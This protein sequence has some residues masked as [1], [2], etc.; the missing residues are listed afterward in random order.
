MLT[1]KAIRM[2]ARMHTFFGP[3]GPLAASLPCFEP[4]SEQADL[5]EAVADALVAD[6]HLVAEAGTGT[7]K[8]LAYLVPALLSGKRIVV[9]TATKALQEQLLAKDVPAAAAALGRPVRCAVLKGRQNYLC[10]KSIH[11]L[12]LLAGAGPALFRTADDAQ[13]FER[14][15]DWVD[16]TTTGDRAELEF[17]PSGSLWSELSVGGDRCAGRRCEFASTCFSE[18]ARER[19]GDSELV[20]V[21]HAL[22]LADVAIRGRGDGAGI[23][24]EHDA[25]VFDEAHRLEEVA[26]AWFGGRVSL[27]RLRLLARDAERACREHEAAPPARVLADVD[28]LGAAVLAELEP[29]SGR[30]RLT[31]GILAP[32]LDAALA[33]SAA[34]AE[35]ARSLAG[36]GEEADAVGRRALAVAD[37]LEACLTLDDPDRV[38]WAEPSAVAWA[39][40]DVS[41]ILR[42]EL[43]ERQVTAVVLSATL[44]RN[45]VRERL[46]LLE[47]HELS[48]A[49]PFDFHSQALLYAPVGLPEPRAPGALDRVAD[50]V[51]ALC[52]LSRGRALVLTSS[53]RALD[54]LVERVGPRLSYPVLCQGDAPRERLLER[55]RDDVDS[56]LFATATFWQGVDVQG[57]SLSLVVIDKLPFASPGDPLVEARCER[58]AREGGD[59]FAGYALP[60]AVLQLRQGFGRLIRS[61]ADSGVVA[62][63][64]PRLR[65]RGYGRRFLEALPPVPVVSDLGD[66]S[67]FFAQELRAT[68]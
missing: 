41:E 51:L 25:V 15:R 59:W 50:E 26:A 60:C 13:E 37:D 36:V 20:I 61:H 34:L 23:L 54:G 43:W 39:P 57:E 35:L 47:A 42:E 62:V 3:D 63:L 65:T 46:G 55:F 11:G 24:P 64:D 22:Y 19:A 27:A 44:D 67:Q 52:R 17:E 18:L 49:S 8:S 53:Y 12:E 45:L 30:V 9:S 48:V 1:G 28:R 29:P 5:A 16:S 14:L 7:G 32:A 33:L 38:S 21:N 2:T 66:V 68:A 31:A 56:V 10:R 6:E 4:R 58:I 40:V